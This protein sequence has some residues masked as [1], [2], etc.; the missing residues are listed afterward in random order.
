VADLSVEIAGVT[1]KNPF[2]LSAAEPTESFDKMK[3][4]IDMGA[5]AVV[6]KSYSSG[7]EMKRQTDIAKYAVLG[8]DR[9]PAYGKDIPKFFTFSCRTGMIQMPEDDWMEELRKTQ[10]YAQKFD[11][12]VIGSVA[13]QPTIA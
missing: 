8:Y 6:A 13:G 9:R 1:L 4:A 10:Q 11:A 5:G 7:Q 3:R 12:E 2:M